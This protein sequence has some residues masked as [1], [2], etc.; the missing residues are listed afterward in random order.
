MS[1]RE[2]LP[3][4]LIGSPKKSRQMAGMIALYFIYGE[5]EET[6]RNA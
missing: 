1:N 5:N 4:W 3:L 2:R 6:T